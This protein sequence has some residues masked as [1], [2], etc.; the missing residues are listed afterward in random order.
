MVQLLDVVEVA[1]MGLW[2]FP[3]S[4]ALIA[5]NEVPS[6]D[7]VFNESMTEGGDAVVMRWMFVHGQRT[8]W[9]DRGMARLPY[10]SLNNAG[11]SILPLVFCSKIQA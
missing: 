3:C 10:Q 5:I 2:E 9:M 6:S 7:L 1:Q 8:L 11:E 4:Y